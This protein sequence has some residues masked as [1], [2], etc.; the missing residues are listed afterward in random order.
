M[1]HFEKLAEEIVKIMRA[2]KSV[3]PPVLNSKRPFEAV[4]NGVTERTD[5][6]EL[7]SGLNEAIVHIAAVRSID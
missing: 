3:S 2:C 6:E 4:I 5:D 7:I 1:L